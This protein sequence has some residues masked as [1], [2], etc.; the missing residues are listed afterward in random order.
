MLTPTGRGLPDHRQR[1]PTAD[2]PQMSKLRWTRTTSEDDVTGLGF[3]I[4]VGSDPPNLSRDRSKRPASLAPFLLTDFSGRVPTV[5]LRAVRPGEPARRPMTVTEAATTGIIGICW[6][7]CGLVLLGVW[8]IRAHGRRHWRRCRV[9]CWRLLGSLRRW[10]PRVAGT[11]WATLRQPLMRGGLL[12]EMAMS[13]LAPA[14]RQNDL[15]FCDHCPPRPASRHN[16]SGSEGG[17]RYVDF[18]HLAHSRQLAVVANDVLSTAM[19]Y[20]TSGSSA[21]SR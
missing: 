1:R 14:T 13:D 20:L 18:L 19:Q 12:P 3:T 4:M 10:T 2:H 17:A 21:G 5:K 11:L 16:L 9:V 6:W 15:G 8:R 7:R